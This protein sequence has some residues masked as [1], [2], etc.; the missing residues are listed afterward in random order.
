MRTGA[1]EMREPKYSH[2]ERERRWLVDP[3]L[4]PDLSTQPY[5]LIE[6]RYIHQTRIRLRRMTDSVS[7]EQS[8]KLTKKYECEDPCARPIV[9]SYLTDEEYRVFAA[10]DAVPLV[11]RR[12]KVEEGGNAFSIDLFA[13]GLAG[14][15]LAEIEWPDDAGLRSLQAPLWAV[16]EVSDDVRYQ[17]GALASAGIPKDRRWQNS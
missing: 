4:R 17:G 14:L 3:A 12:F 11:K 6:D 2:I 13:G 8:L 5:V 10:L 9:T 1:N 15:E 7:R 16:C